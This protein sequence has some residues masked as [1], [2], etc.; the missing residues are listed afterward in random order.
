MRRAS[1]LR[2]L[3]TAF[4]LALGL[5]AATNAQAFELEIQKVTPRVYALVGSIHGR[6]AENMA[7]NATL[8]L[9]LAEDGV[10]LIDSGA[11]AQ[12]AALVASEIA[13]I[14][15]LPVRWVINT[16]AQDHRWLGNGYFRDH[17][18]EIYAL[19]RTV[20]SQKAY[21]AQHLKRLE[22]V[23]GAPQPDTIP[24]YA[25]PPLAGDA[26]ELTLGG[27]DVQIRWLGGAHFPNEVVVAVP[28]EGTV[29]AGDLVFNDRMLGIQ[30]D[31]ASVVRDWAATFDAM[32]AL[33]PAHV[34]PGHGHAGDLAKA[35]ADTGDYLHWLLDNIAPAVEDFEDIE[36][37]MDRLTDSP[38]R[39]LANY[40][41]WQ[42][43]NVNF[44]YLQL[45]VE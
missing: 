28:S 6:D 43:R 38:F 3:A 23:M 31:G 40:D 37:V 17:G 36:E 44:T 5:L 15:D 45:E 24:T 22:S 16:G 30:P 42:R 9:V 25:D 10:I 41:A 20:E 8:G 21:A 4:T 33:N 35:R 32:A 11:S 19:A 26:A 14:T 27:V 18:A 29:F 39:H 1:I 34:V 7:L 12:G 2:P 13:Q